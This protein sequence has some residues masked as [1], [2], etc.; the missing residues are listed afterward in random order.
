MNKI[1][2]VAFAVVFALTSCSSSDDDGVGGPISTQI[3][4]LI[5]KG[6]FVQGSE[7]TL[8]DLNKD[9]SQ[10]GKSFSTNTSNDL[11]NF[12]FDQ[13]LDLSSGLV[14]LKTSGYFYNECTG[15]LSNSLLTLKAI[16][17]ANDSKKLNVNLLTHLEY[18]R[19]KKLV[20]DG[21]TFR[22]AKVQA[23]KEILKAFAITDKIDSP[24]KV[25]LIDNNKDASILL[26]ISSI[27]L[28]NKSEAEFSEFI[29]KFSSDLEKDG[30]IDDQSIKDKIINGQTNC[31]PSS[32]IESMENFYKDKGRNININD[33][34]TFVD[35]NGDGIIDEND[36]EIL[37][38][39][40]KDS[41]SADP[42]FTSEQHIKI[43]LDGLYYHSRS[44]INSL[45]D[46]DLT[47]LN[48][49]NFSDINAGSG[50]VNN[51]WSDGYSIC[52]NALTIE[53]NLM[54]N[55]Y[56][57][58]TN[59]Y[60]SQS[61]A[62]RAFVIYNMAMH[63][64]NIPLLTKLNLN[65]IDYEPIPSSPEEQYKYA[66]N[67]VNNLDF[68]KSESFSYYYLSSN[69]VNVLKAELYLALGNKNEAQKVLKNVPNENVFLYPDENNIKD[70]EIYSAQY[71]EYLKEEANGTDN[72]AKWFTDRKEY[73]GTFAALK[74]LGKIQTL[75][76]ID[77]HYNLLPIPRNEILVN[78][79]LIQNPGY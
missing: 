15:S 56:N 22:N 2:F 67:L 79:Y 21:A 49:E 19:V 44:F 63:W 48:N 53:E 38:M 6:P 76:G 71:I 41:I 42:L 33:F 28:Y 18:A 45:S 64:G 43:A 14:E 61:K 31:H 17:N 55:K 29:A 27:M 75:T 7:V 13:T 25:S 73:Y 51:A 3:F 30:K 32:I 35:F 65:Q 74:R 69:A 16:A 10:S 47:R 23:E 37:D 58:D 78:H 77:T 4:G 36:K 52:R 39:V 54:K 50:L 11:G 68:G 34:S 40:P 24:E 5:E 8:T 9:L 46:I 57:F 62:L 66:L 72:S 12:E 26:A 1:L 60:I 20:K 70:I 59:S